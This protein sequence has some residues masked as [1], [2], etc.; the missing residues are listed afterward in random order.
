MQELKSAASQRMSDILAQAGPGKQAQAGRFSNYTG[1]SSSSYSSSSS[2][3]YGGKSVD[4]RELRSRLERAIDIMQT[5]LVERD[6]EVRSLQTQQHCA[7]LYRVSEITFMTRCTVLRCGVPFLACFCWCWG[8]GGGGIVASISWMG[9]S[10]W[11]LG[12][13]GYLQGC[14]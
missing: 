2:S 6:T 4:T 1:S 8:D 10:S 12:G 5:G 7:V 11:V 9:C 3:S 13:V 14:A